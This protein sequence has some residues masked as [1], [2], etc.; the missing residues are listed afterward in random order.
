MH[1]MGRRIY[2]GA[3]MFAAA[4]AVGGCSL[5]YGLGGYPPYPSPPGASPGPSV[6]YTSG[7]ATIAIDKGPTIE[8]PTMTEGGTVVPEFGVSA[9]FRNDDGWYLRIMGAT[10]GRETFAS[11][12][13]LT[14]DRIVDGEHW[15]TF[16][17]GRCKFTITAAD[18]SGLVGT[19]SC[20]GL[21]WSDAISTGIGETYEPQYIDQPP[22][23]AEIMFEA[24]PSSTRAS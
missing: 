10:T 1:G 24:A 22:F 15:T 11:T 2:W 13:Y 6:K 23:D 16:D 17:P 14:L 5:L 9:S 21:R 20:S 19:A 8:L 18:A 4:M 7:K 12:T 3:V